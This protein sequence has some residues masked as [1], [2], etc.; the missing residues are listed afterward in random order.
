MD[1]DPSGKDEQLNE[2]ICLN[3]VS[4]LSDC[5]WSELNQNH[6]LTGS[7]DGTVALWDVNTSQGDEPL[8]RWLE[9]D[10]IGLDWNIIDKES[11][12]TASSDN[13]IKMFRPEILDSIQTFNCDMSPSSVIWSPHTPEGFASSM[14]DGSMKTWDTRQASHSASIMAH[15]EEA[16][17]V[18]YDK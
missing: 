3:S 13:T 11:F 14:V 5:S 1:I 12:L 8:S 15:T 10:I 16:L 2:I 9:H 18:D 6:I 17:T 4:G 7:T